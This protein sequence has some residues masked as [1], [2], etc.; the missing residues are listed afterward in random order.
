M[1]GS[2]QNISVLRTQVAKEVFLNPTPGRVGIVAKQYVRFS[3]SCQFIASYWEDLH[4]V[5]SLA[6]L[7]PSFSR[8]SWES[9]NEIV[10]ALLRHLA[11]IGKDK[12]SMYNIHDT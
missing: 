7:R 5:N 4:I 1:L 11:G 2:F 3:Y 9:Q 10:D 8:P 6:P 12:C